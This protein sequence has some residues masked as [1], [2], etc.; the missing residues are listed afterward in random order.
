VAKDI[1]VDLWL[2]GPLS[3]YGAAGDESSHVNTQ[4][5]LPRASRL[6]DLLS[7]LELPTGERGFTFINGKLTATPGNQPDL[8]TALHDGDRVAFFHLKS[9]WPMQYRDGA[10]A[11]PDLNG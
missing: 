7:H 3:R 8:D 11:S 6:R 5:R 10:Q 1:T 2:Y 4:V 9:M